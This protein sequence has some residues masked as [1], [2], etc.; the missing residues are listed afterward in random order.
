MTLEYSVSTIN[1]FVSACSRI[2]AIVDASKRVFNAFITGRQAIVN[3]DYYTRDVQAAIIKYNLSQV[4]AQ[5][6]IYYLNNAA[7]DV[8]DLSGD[9]FHALSEAYGFILSLQ[10]TNDGSGN[11]YMTHQ[12]VMTMLSDLEA[13]NGL[14]DR[15]AAELDAMAAQ[16]QAAA[17]L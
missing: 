10:F 17:G 5:R 11:A 3:Q 15:T 6:A 7:Y 12:E 16:V 14:W 4:V 2:N 1:T 13:G 8:A 9:Y